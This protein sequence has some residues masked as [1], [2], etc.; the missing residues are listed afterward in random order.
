MPMPNLTR[1]TRSTVRVIT[2]TI[3]GLAVT[4]ATA[5]GFAQSYSGLY[6]WALEH[7]LSGWKAESFPLLVDLFV[8]CGELGLFLLALDGYKLAKKSGLSW[9]DLLIPTCVASIGWGVSLWFNVGHVQ[10]ATFDD[11]VTAGVPPVTAMVG[12]VILLR[13]VHRYMAKLDEDSDSNVTDE[14]TW[15]MAKDPVTQKIL[16]QIEA[17]KIT[18]ALDVP[19]T[20]GEIEPTERAGGQAEP[21]TP[22]A[23]PARASNG[24]A[25]RHAKWDEGVR[26]YRESLTG[27][28]KALSQRDLASELGMSN[29]SLAAKIIRYVEKESSNADSE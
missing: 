8:L 26:I 6:R 17:N 14:S 12:L 18:E 24:Y 7:Q 10:N 23:L 9:V 28:G 25:S 13:N 4:I 11:K 29:R 1:F 5:D 15:N 19:A 3:L 2:V 16:A 22:V 27:P 20:A 21:L